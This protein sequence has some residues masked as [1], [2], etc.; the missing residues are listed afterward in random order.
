MN[1]YIYSIIGDKKQKIWDI[2]FIYLSIH[3]KEKK[4]KKKERKRHL[5]KSCGKK[6]N[7]IVK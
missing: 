5:L 4:K 1:I 3:G 2:Y 6:V 7:G